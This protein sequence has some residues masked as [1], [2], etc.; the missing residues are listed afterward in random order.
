M[1]SLERNSA[2]YYKNTLKR[3]KERYYEKLK[4]AKLKKWQG[5]QVKPAQPVEHVPEV[6]SV[7]RVQQVKPVQRVERVPE[8]KEVK[9]KKVE[10]QVVSYQSQKPLDA[11]QQRMIYI[12][13]LLNTFEMYPEFDIHYYRNQNDD[14][15]HLS[16]YDLV[17]HWNHYG[18]NEKEKRIYN[19]ETFMERYPNVYKEHPIYIF[20]HVCTLHNGIEIFYDQLKSIVDCGLYEKCKNI[21]V[22]VVGQ[23]FEIPRDQYPKMMLLYQEDNPKYYE[24]KTINYLKYITERINPKSRILYIHTKGVRKNGDE[25]CV[26]S[27]RKLLEYWM[28]VQHD[29]ALQYLTHYDTVGSNVINMAPSN[30]PSKK[31]LF[32][33]NPNHFFHYSGNFWWATAEH[34]RQLP[35]L[36]HNP[37]KDAMSTR[38]RAENWILSRLPHM[39]GFEIYYQKNY[40]HPYNTYCDPQSYM[41][42]YIEIFT[43]RNNFDI[44]RDS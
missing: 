6:K 16:H 23:P 42:K 44:L 30:E 17:Y 18:S 39:R 13:Y 37:Y 21:L 4:H 8:V 12:Q 28:V 38:C 33:V 14:L 34:I 2:T 40:V 22:C 36:D 24:V 43:G 41:K 1:N 29:I 32:A 3:E 11:I 25:V 31:Y 19:R 10:N 35:N 7:E 5:Q 9:K 26:K 15:K 20:M 27:W